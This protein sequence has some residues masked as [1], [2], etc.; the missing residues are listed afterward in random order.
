M[1]AGGNCA[2]T[3]KNRMQVDNPSYFVHKKKKHQ[4]EPLHT[5]RYGEQAAK[6]QT[7]PKV[8]SI[9]MNEIVSKDEKENFKMAH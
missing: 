5:S 9:D 7:L 3:A 6:A 2:L 1:N 4:A 8:K